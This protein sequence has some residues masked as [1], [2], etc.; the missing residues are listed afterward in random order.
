[1]DP[2][3]LPLSSSTEPTIAAIDGQPGIDPDDV[4]SKYKGI[5][6]KGLNELRR[7]VDAASLEVHLHDDVAEIS[8]A[9][10]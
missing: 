3:Y 4:R 9:S 8:L 10:L 2:R 7:V 6:E 5:A 1:M